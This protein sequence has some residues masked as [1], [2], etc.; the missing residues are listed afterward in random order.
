M[1]IIGLLLFIFS[2]AQASENICTKSWNQPY[3]SCNLLWSDKEGVE[4]GLEVAYRENDCQVHEGGKL[5][6]CLHFRDCRNQ[7]SEHLKYLYLEKTKVDYFCSHG[8]EFVI[9]ED[10]PTPG[11]KILIKCLNKTPSEIVLQFKDKQKTCSFLN[12]LKVSP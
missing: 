11:S 8:D 12:G 2:F 4:W 7:D 9:S 1:K 3:P 10:K 5:L 6:S